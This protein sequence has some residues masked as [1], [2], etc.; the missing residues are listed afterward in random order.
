MLR[1]QLETSAHKRS[2]TMENA[3]RVVQILVFLAFIYLFLLT[4]GQVKIITTASGTSAVLALISR[5]PVDTFLRIDPLIGAAT[6]LAARKVIYVLLWYGLPIVLLTILAGRFFC[7]WLC[8][9]GT[10]LDVSD[11]LFFHKRNHILRQTQSDSSTTCWRNTKYYLL[12]VILFGSL[13]SAQI[14]YFFDPIALLTRTL[15]LAFV[16]PIQMVMRGLGENAP[17]LSHN[18]FFPDGQMFFR[19]NLVALL[20]FIGII[21]ANYYSRRFWCRN[22]CPLGAL[23]ALFSRFSAI[24]RIVGE[25]CNS[26]RLCEHECKMASILSD[27]GEYL[28]P[29]CIYCYSCTQACSKGT[30][31]IVPSLVNR[32]Y[33]KDLSLNRRRLIQAFGIGLAWTAVVKTHVSAKSARD[34]KIKT[35]SPQL[36]RPP[37]AQAEDQFLATC[38]RCAECMKVCPTNGLQPSILEAGL[39][40]FWTPVLVPKIGECTQNCNLCGN[41]CS[42]QSIKPFTVEEKTFMFMGT[43]VIDRSMC[44]AWN[45]NKPCLVCDEYCSYHAIKWKTVE[46]VRRPFV[47]DKKCTGCGTCESACPIQPQSAVRI[48]SFGDKRHLTRDEQRRWSEMN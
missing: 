25:G 29:E 14:A 44:I 11:T 37:G 47:N 5:A 26:C 20:I 45:S 8:P 3:R 48:F 28:A 43:A 46:G 13:F 10:A 32:G 23:L 15:T 35:S 40:G 36:I 27:P 19:L 22:L 41:V 16:A 17:I 30:T 4:I 42:T 9:L 39:E 12:A 6:M 18:R 2:F 21:A 31:K 1:K 7:G 33:R 38:I 24:R 34:S